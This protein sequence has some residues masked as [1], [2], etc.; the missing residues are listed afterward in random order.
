MDTILLFGD[1][2]ISTLFIF[3]LN[4]Q[5]SKLYL[6]ITSDEPDPT[7][8]LSIKRW[9]YE[10]KAL[11]WVNL[12]RNNLQRKFCFYRIKPIELILI[13]FRGN[14]CFNSSFIKYYANIFIND[15]PLVTRTWASSHPSN[16]VRKNGFTTRASNPGFING[17]VDM[18]IIKVWHGFYVTRII[19]N[20][21]SLVVFA[22]LFLLNKKGI[23]PVARGPN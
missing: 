23:T 13:K 10:S 8:L 6:F 12:R 5:I 19:A 18:F 22:I 20:T 16:G 3:K 14:D 4:I 9:Y 11:T 2:L 15:R 7:I 1:H 17:G 21:R